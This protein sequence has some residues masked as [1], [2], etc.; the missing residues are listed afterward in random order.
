MQYQTK[1]DAGHLWAGGLSRSF[2]RDYSLN[3]MDKSFPGYF[4]GAGDGKDA[5]TYLKTIG[6]ASQLRLGRL[7]EIKPGKYR[8]ED[9][10]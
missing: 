3:A 8:V 6:D 4:D 10:A 2:H 9:D 5:E 1:A 7:W